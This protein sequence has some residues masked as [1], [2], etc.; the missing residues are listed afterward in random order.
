MLVD[1]HCNPLELYCTYRLGF[2]HVSASF[3]KTY[4]EPYH[5]K[6]ALS[7]QQA[8]QARGSTDRGDG[9]IFSP[10]F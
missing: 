9:H 2:W 5:V 7:F 1:A 6:L 3:K 10:A 4:L 8:A